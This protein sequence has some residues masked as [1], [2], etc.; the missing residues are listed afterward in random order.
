MSGPLNAPGFITGYARWNN[1]AQIRSVAG[2]FT[3][4]QSQF[5]EANRRLATECQANAVEALRASIVRPNVSTERL[6][7]AVAAAGDR[8]S[9]QFEWGVGV[10]AFLDQSQAKYWRTIEE[11]TLAVWKHPFTGTILRGTWGGSIA[12]SY[13][14][15]WGVVPRGGP[16]IPVAAGG[17]F[18]PVP[19]RK[20]GRSVYR[21]GTRGYQS[22]EKRIGHAQGSVVGK[23]IEPHLFFR[24][25]FEQLGGITGVQDVY[26]QVFRETL[27]RDIIFRPGRA[28]T[29]R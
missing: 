17:K 18:I 25:G 4:M 6:E 23:E 12:G 19:E 21:P 10:S 7:T 1:I 20:G 5:A 22:A 15:R 28:P 2:R 26:R 9:D 8:Y 11:G 29:L 27:G 13:T 24:K 14:N 16:P 3:S